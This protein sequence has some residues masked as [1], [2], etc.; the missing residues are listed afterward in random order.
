MPAM[1]A[2][3]TIVTVLPWAD[4]L[5]VALFFGGWLAYAQWARRRAERAV[6]LDDSLPEAHHS[7]GT[8]R[9]FDWDLQG[10]EKELLR[11][12]SIN[13]NLAESH[14][15]LSAVL[16]GLDRFD[17]AIAAGQ[18][19][20]ELDPYS[21]R[22]HLDL[23]FA[24]FYAGRYDQCVEVCRK[25]LLIESKY[26][27]AHLD[28]GRAYEQKGMHDLA[29]AELIK[30]RE[31]SRDEPL[32]LAALGHVYAVSGRTA[33]ARNML[34]LLLQ[35]AQKGNVRQYE[36]GKVYAGLGDADRAFEWL[37]KAY[38][39]RAGFL[40]FVRVEPMLDGLRKDTR[41]VGLMK[42]IEN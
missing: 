22:V 5:A 17:D 13:A 7:L 4:W 34:D 14:S 25:M 39:E 37:E 16:Q 35:A 8:A 27:P 2:L 42:G 36:I 24:Y 28:L 18:R 26:W 30:A 41:F 19:A 15:R 6:Q 33:E 1:N 20:L 9:Y 11:A 12:I 3:Q 31:F 10:A 32:T 38:E 23:Q 40:A 21:L 29:I